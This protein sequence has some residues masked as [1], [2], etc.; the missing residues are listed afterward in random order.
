MSLLT[1][2]IIKNSHILTRIYFSFLK[3]CHRPNLKEFQYQIFLKTVPKA[4]ELQKL[5]KESN[6][7]GSRAS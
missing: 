7:K 1:V 4:L 3:Q 2:L 6:L 5:S